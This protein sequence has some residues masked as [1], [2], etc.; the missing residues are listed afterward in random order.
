MSNLDLALSRMLETTGCQD[1]LGLTCLHLCPT[2]GWVAM[3]A[4]GVPRAVGGCPLLAR[5]EPPWGATTLGY[6]PHTPGCPSGR[7]PVGTKGNAGEVPCLASGQGS[8]GG[9]GAAWG[10][11]IWEE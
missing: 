3:G 4:V 6:K 2:P 1:R 9:C 11:G 8:C 10:S 5:A 7:A